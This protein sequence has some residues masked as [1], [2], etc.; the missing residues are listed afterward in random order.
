MN[1]VVVAVIGND[2]LAQRLLAHGLWP[3]AVVERLQQAP[4]GD[5]MLFRLHGFRLALRRGEADRVTVA[6]AAS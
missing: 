3:G 5:P 1:Y 4:F 6:E 2:A